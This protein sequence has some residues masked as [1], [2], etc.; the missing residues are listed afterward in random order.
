M[1]SLPWRAGR[2]P[3]PAVR[4]TLRQWPRASSV[5]NSQAQTDRDSTALTSWSS[6][7]RKM[8]TTTT[9]IGFVGL[10]HMGGNMAARF[11]AADYLVM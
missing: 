2:V 11:L 7:G 9:K 10:G 6:K 1:T 4:A 5:S 3:V 8:A